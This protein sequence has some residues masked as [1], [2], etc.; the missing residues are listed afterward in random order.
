MHWAKIAKLATFLALLATVAIGTLPAF[1]WAKAGLRSMAERPDPIV[2]TPEETRAILGAVLERM[3]LIGAPPPPPEPGEAPR[4]E[5]K[6]ILVL[7]DQS[8][9]LAETTKPGC[10][11]E[12]ADDLLISEL[13]AFAPRK[14]RLELVAANQAPQHLDLRGIPATKVVS[15]SEIQKIF[16]GGWWDDFYKRYPATSG[17]VRVSQS[18][19]TKDRQQALI[20]VAHYCGGLCG[21]GTVLLLKRSGST[22]RIVKKEMLWIS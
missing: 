2:A 13:D 16:K 22:W 19:L 20:Y 10:V 3:K 6:R 21:T 9:C 7:A 12:F 18:V 4:P 11:S 8:L 17:F 1:H 5:L 15:S 14:L